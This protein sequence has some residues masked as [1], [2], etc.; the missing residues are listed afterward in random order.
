MGE[1]MK[2]YILFGGENY[3]KGGM[4]DFRAMDDE[5]YL[6][7]NKA[8]ELV[9]E[10]TIEWWHV[11]DTESFHIVARSEFQSFNVEKED[12]VPDL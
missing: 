9:A 7:T 5:I 8:A 6:L 3:A 10:D 11:I 1:Q 4:N 12:F 2:R